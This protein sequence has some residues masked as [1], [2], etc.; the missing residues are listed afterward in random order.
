VSKYKK[1]IERKESENNAKYGRFNSQEIPDL[2]SILHPYTDAEIGVYQFT[3]SKQ[4]CA[5]ENKVS[6]GVFYCL[7]TKSEYANKAIVKERMTNHSVCAYCAPKM[8][9]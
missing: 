1:V 6:T 9:I 8:G 3:N 4:T 2:F 5:F 7:L